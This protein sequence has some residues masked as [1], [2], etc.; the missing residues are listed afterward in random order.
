MDTEAGGG[1]WERAWSPSEATLIRLVRPNADPMPI[2]SKPEWE[3]VLELAGREQVTSLVYAAIGGRDG[4]PVPDPVARELAESYERAARRA[5]DAFAQLAEVLRALHASRRQV[6]VIK[7][8]ALACSTYQ[9]IALRTFN[10]VDLLARVEDLEAVDQVLRTVGYVPADRLPDHP[11]RAR[12]RELTYY[13]PFWRRLPFDVHWAYTSYPHLWE[14]DYEGVFARACHV[15]ADGGT[16]VVPSP[17][18]M[19]VALSTHLMVDLWQSRPKLRYL[20][21]VSEV[22]SR[23]PVDWRGLLQQVDAVPSLRS[24]LRLTLKVAADLL[25]API[26]STILDAL[27]PRRGIRADHSLG[28][29][30]CRDVLRR[31]SPTVALM[32][33]LLIRWMDGG[34]LEGSVDLV[35]ARVE[36]QW[37]RV[38]AFLRRRASAA[39]RGLPSWWF[40]TDR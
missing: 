35:R 16:V 1:P 21:D 13:D 26:P 2:L 30:L 7:G 14:L 5:G 23:R 10:D 29:W 24:P 18:D 28:G 9:N 15:R 12:H 31:A 34:S 25:G 37:H 40:R 6:V 36:A 22:V 39:R 38:R 17:A 20:R 32:H 33:M 27:R 19:L 11:E 3:G 8:A 4:G